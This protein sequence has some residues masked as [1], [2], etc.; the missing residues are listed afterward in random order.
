MARYQQLPNRADT[1]SVTIPD[2]AMCFNYGLRNNCTIID[3][4]AKNQLNIISGCCCEWTVPPGVTS[5]VI[6]MWGAGGGGGGQSYCCCCAT[7]VAGSAGGYISATV[8]TIP[9]SKYTLCAGSGGA[10]GCN[11]TSGGDGNPS[12]ASGLNLS[13]F[14]AGGGRGGPSGCNTCERWCYGFNMY[15]D[16]SCGVIG[17]STLAGN[18]IRACGEGGHVFGRPQG[19]RGDT[20]GGSAPMNG[21]VGGWSTYNHCCPYTPYQSEGGHFPG[22]GGAGANETCCCGICTC[23]GC[24]GGGLVRIWF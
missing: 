8:S 5:F 11:T 6:E 12:Y 20:K 14:C 3:S 7:G 10:M 2:E 15:N 24:G 21:G 18:V 4:A 19:C 16:S 23:G 1:I 9:G 22:G 13:G 17:S